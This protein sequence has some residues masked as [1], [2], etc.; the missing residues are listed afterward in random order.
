M[1]AKKAL[2]QIVGKNHPIFKET[3]FEKHTSM[4]FNIDESVKACRELEKENVI[5]EDTRQDSAGQPVL[6]INPDKVQ[7]KPSKY[8]GDAE[9]WFIKEDTPDSRRLKNESDLKDLLNYI[10]KEIKMLEAERDHKVGTT[11][12][13]IDGKIEALEGVAIQIRRKI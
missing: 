12:P 2:L 11:F 8:I 9:V 7:K 1:N 4:G 10:K 13:F 3:C 6:E 5:V